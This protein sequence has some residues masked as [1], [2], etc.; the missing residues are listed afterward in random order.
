M[1]ILVID[2]RSRFVFR[3]ID[4]KTLRLHHLFHFRIFSLDKNHGTRRTRLNAS[5]L[6]PPIFKEMYTKGTFLRYLFLFVP[7]N[8]VIRACFKD[9]FLTLCFFWI[10]DDNTV[11]LL[12]YRSIAF[13]DTRSVIAMHTGIGQIGHIDLRE[14][15]PF[16]P[17]NVHPSVAMPRLRDRVRQ[18]IVLEVLVFASEKAV[19]TIVAF[20]DV[21]NHVPLFHFLFLLVLFYFNKARVWCHS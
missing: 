17:K 14:L 11:F 1:K 15:A 5:R 12:V 2:P 10:Y 8:N 3:T 4:L 16:P 6:L 19:I 9:L 21:H 13:L 7:V 20:C 18:K